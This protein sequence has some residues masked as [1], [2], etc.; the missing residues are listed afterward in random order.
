M[1]SEL[2][3][4]PLG[5]VESIFDRAWAYMLKKCDGRDIVHLLSAIEIQL[6]LPP[7][8]LTL[9]TI[10]QQKMTTLSP[11]AM[12]NYSKDEFLLLLMRVLSEIKVVDL[13]QGTVYGDFG[14][15]HRVYEDNHN[16]LLYRKDTNLLYGKEVASHQ[17][18]LQESPTLCLVRS[19]SPFA[20]DSDTDDTSS[21]MDAI[22]FDR[23]SSIW[24]GD[25]FEAFNLRRMLEDLNTHHFSIHLSFQTIGHKLEKLKLQNSRDLAFLN[26]LGSSNEVIREKMHD[27]RYE[28]ADLLA[29][30]EEFKSRGRD[31]IL[32]ENLPTGGTEDEA[33]AEA[34]EIPLLLPHRGKNLLG[35]SILPAE[36]PE[37]GNPLA[38][39]TMHEVTLEVQEF[40]ATA[41][42]T[43][44]HRQQEAEKTVLI[45]HP[46]IWA[47]LLSVTAVLV[48][49]WLHKS[50][51]NI[52]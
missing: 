23:A 27:I 21:L 41:T 6:E 14:D 50:H 8:F 3:T 20:Y 28:L 5:R 1:D 48:H 42:K 37:I 47:V 2:A 11:A 16:N 25:D 12:Q 49:A 30:V 40:T 26:R 29:S 13:H 44:T 15:N 18:V 19:G 45:T 51:E 32:G 43:P 35:S 36:D 52:I 17:V 22:P 4:A 9:D 10:I 34:D 39:S 46:L 38:G 7:G 33:K 31:T 24:S